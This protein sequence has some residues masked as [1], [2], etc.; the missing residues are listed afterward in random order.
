MNDLLNIRIVPVAQ[1]ASCKRSQVLQM[2]VIRAISIAQT[3]ADCPGA[4]PIC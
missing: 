3:I 1:S 2:Y 4:L